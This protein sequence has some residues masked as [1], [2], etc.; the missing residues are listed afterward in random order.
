LK[1]LKHLFEK[2]VK[3]T[4]IDSCNQIITVNVQC[5]CVQEYSVCLIIYST[6]VIDLQKEI[7]RPTLPPPSAE[8]TPFLSKVNR[9]IKTAPERQEKNGKASPR[10]DYADNSNKQK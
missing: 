6:D 4:S 10:V 3:K 7:I 9:R 8:T 2:F 5:E 1:A